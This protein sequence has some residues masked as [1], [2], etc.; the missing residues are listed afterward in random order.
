[1]NNVTPSYVVSYHGE[2]QRARAEELAARL[3][4][5]LIPDTSHHPFRLMVTEAGLELHHQAQTNARPT[6]LRCDM[7]S[8]EVLRRLAGGKSQDLAKAVGIHSSRGKGQPLPY[9]LDATAGLG[10]DSF[11]LAHL[12]CRVQMVER[13]PLIATL[14][15]DGL[16]R[17]RQH[18]HT[19]SVTARLSL[20]QADARDVLR[21]LTHHPDITYPTVIYLD[22]MYPATNKGA[23]PKKEMQVLRQLLGADDVTGLLEHALAVKDTRIVVKR[24]KHAPS[25]P[26][27]N[28]SFKGKQTRFDVYV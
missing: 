14:L 3:E 17:G 15:A 10:R 11:V 25:T 23:L 8:S 26:K 22:P 27:P 2:A 24:P 7:G 19:A 13:H 28:T 16:A 1:K 20:V 6:I 21:S 4:Q 9:V 5:A 18:P 12:G